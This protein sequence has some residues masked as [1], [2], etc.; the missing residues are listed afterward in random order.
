MQ[1]KVMLVV[2]NEQCSCYFFL[3]TFEKLPFME[4]YLQQHSTAQHS[5]VSHTWFL[6]VGQHT[7]LTSESAAAMPLPPPPPYLSFAALTRASRSSTGNSRPCTGVK[8]QEVVMPDV[9]PVRF[10]RLFAVTNKCDHPPSI[11][12]VTRLLLLLLAA[13]WAGKQWPGCAHFASLFLS[14]SLHAACRCHSLRPACQ[15]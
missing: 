6:L 12:G 4:K 5:T 9:P 11:I 1:L 7:V 10:W 2:F 8:A 3:P 13:G 14:S 15:E